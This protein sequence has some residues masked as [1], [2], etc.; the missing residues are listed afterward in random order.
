MSPSTHSSHS[1][2]RPPGSVTLN[3]WVV[4]VDR[5]RAGSVSS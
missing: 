1:G 2:G 4:R 3:V 5:A